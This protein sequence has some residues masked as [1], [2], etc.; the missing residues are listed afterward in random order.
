M[1]GKKKEQLL[2]DIADY[3]VNTQLDDFFIS[4]QIEIANMDMFVIYICNLL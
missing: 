2:E 3:I 4:H 1:A